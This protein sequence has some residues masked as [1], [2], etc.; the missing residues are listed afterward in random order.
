M[1]IIDRTINWLMK[2]A[3]WKVMIYMAIFIVMFWAFT[4]FGIV[5]ILKQLH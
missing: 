1:G 2:E 3:G 5:W 4:A